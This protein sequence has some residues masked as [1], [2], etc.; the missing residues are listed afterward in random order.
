MEFGFDVIL[1][2]NS[3][4]STMPTKSNSEWRHIVVVVYEVVSQ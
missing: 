1:Y 2:S 4:K 3:K